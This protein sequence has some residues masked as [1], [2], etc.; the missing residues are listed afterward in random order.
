M[1]ERC[2]QACRGEGTRN[3]ILKRF[4]GEVL[5]PDQR[6]ELVGYIREEPRCASK[7]GLRDIQRCCGWRFVQ[8]SR[9]ACASESSWQRLVDETAKYV[10]ALR[11]V[12]H[13]HRQ[14]QT[15]QTGTACWV[16]HQALYG[17]YI[18]WAENRLL[19]YSN[20]GTL[21]NDQAAATKQSDREFHRDKKVADREKAKITSLARLTSDE[22][23]EFSRDAGQPR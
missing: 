5:T 23:L 1:F 20:L 3:G 13:R 8:R 6:I 16:A 2:P 15:P 22:I 19:T 14:L 21:T 7:P 10:S 18:S 4:A 11:T 17:S 12:A 9:H